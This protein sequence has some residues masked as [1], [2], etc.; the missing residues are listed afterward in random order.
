MI[1]LISLIDDKLYTYI[2]PLQV[3]YFKRELISNK[4]SE[5]QTVT[6]GQTT[7]IS[8]AL[9]TCLLESSRLDYIGFYKDFRKLW[10]GSIL[11]RLECFLQS[12]NRLVDPELR[13]S[14]VYAH[15]P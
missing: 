1:Q 14:A 11:P 13:Y 12:I 9:D 7:F 10:A 3:E 15:K 8:Y 2:D 5:E 4:E 6:G